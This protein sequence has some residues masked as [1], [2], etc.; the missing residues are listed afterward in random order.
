MVHDDFYSAV[1]RG[2]TYPQTTPEDGMQNPSLEL[3]YER[4]S[5][6]STVNVAH[7]W[8]WFAST[9]DPPE[10]HSQGP[11][12][13]PEY[14]SLSRSEDA[15]RVWDGETAQCWFIRWRV[16]RIFAAVC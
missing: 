3:P 7:G 2:Y 8:N 9:G 16:M 14:K 15:R 4:D 11:C 6:H 13:L 5:G 10:E 1:E 12:G